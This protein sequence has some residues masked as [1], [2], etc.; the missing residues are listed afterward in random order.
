MYRFVKSKGSGLGVSIAKEI[1]SA[2]GGTIRVESTVG[3]GETFYFT[4]P[5]CGEEGNKLDKK[6]LSNTDLL[7]KPLV[8]LMPITNQN[9]LRTTLPENAL[10]CVLTSAKGKVGRVHKKKRSPVST[11]LLLTNIAILFCYCKKFN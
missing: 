4:V 5:V 7:R 6:K 10:L 1:I 3:E 11:G 2:H 9:Y 8:N